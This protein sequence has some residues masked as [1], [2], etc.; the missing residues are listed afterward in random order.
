M[1]EINTC[2]DLFNS[3]GYLNEQGWYYYERFMAGEFTIKIQEG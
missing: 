2:I 3:Y 1:Y